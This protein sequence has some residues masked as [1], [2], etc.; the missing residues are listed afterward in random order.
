[1]SLNKILFYTNPGILSE[2]LN[3]DINHVYFHL[4]PQARGNYS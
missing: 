2:G 4:L 3:L 1:M